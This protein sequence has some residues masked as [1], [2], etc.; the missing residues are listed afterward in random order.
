VTVA[1]EKEIGNEMSR[2]GLK[3][4]G[5]EV[6]VAK[7]RLVHGMFHKIFGIFFFR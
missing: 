1:T 3:A 4:H 2:V 6:L 5:H 7:D